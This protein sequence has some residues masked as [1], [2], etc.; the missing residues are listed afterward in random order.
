[1]CRTLGI[2]E[3]DHYNIVCATQETS[4]PSQASFYYDYQQVSRTVSGICGD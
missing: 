2:N 4:I 3:V 1:M